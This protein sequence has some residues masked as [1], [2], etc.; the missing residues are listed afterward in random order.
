MRA[1]G[2]ILAVLGSLAIFAW[3]ASSLF[4]LS[5]FESMNFPLGLHA[6]GAGGIVCIGLWLFLERG[7]F[8]NLRNDNSVARGGMVG[9]LLLV[10]MALLVAVNVVGARYDERWDLTSTK[11]YSLSE[12]SVTI[13]KGLETKVDILAFFPKGGMEASDFKE[14]IRGY[15]EAST[16]ITVRHLDPQGDNLAAMQE[17]ITSEYGEVIIRAGAV[18]QRLTT[19]FDEEGI[20]NALVKA[21]TTESHSLCAVGGHGE[22]GADDSSAADGMGIALGKLT[23]QNYIL[24]TVNLLSAQPTPAD[25]EVLLLAGPRTDLSGGEL[26]RLAQYVAA[27]GKMIVLLN[28]LETPNTAADMARYGVKVGADIVI[29]GDPYRQTANGAS[30]VMVAPA[31]YAAHPIV[32]KLGD[33]VLFPLARSAA[34]GPEVAGLTVTELLH[35]TDQSWAES[36]LSDLQGVPP[37]PDPGVDPI[38]NVSLMVAVE[39]TDPAAIAEATVAA[40]VPVLEGAPALAPPPAVVDRLPKA[41]GGRLVVIGDADF[42]T[43]SF[44]NQGANQDLLLNSVGWMAGDTKQVTIHANDAKRGQI[45]VDVVPGIVTVL[46]AML[47]VPGLATAGAVV[48]YLRRRNQ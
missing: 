20:T 3:G 43:N 25:C 12:Q 1:I 21:T 24:S 32:E 31:S 37:A 41:A 13:A 9:V 6:L 27:G 34:K 40:V 38:G 8:S 18:E 26:D 33:A 44:S 47:G 42:G 39:V 23:K 19:G 16:L 22:S 4:L 11:R 46:L 2:Q 48:T 17:K 45:T 15:E 35:T 30:F 5:M 29:E 14:L 10:A 7:S 36:N 28:P